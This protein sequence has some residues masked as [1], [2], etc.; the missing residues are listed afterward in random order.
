MRRLFKALRPG[1]DDACPRSCIPQTTKPASEGCAL[2]DPDSV[3]HAAPPVRQV[4]EL[5]VD[6]LA[7]LERGQAQ[8]LAAPATWPV[9][10]HRDT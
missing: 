10:A 2:L 9:R 3:V 1:G 5:M 7:W 8:P 6:L 4:P